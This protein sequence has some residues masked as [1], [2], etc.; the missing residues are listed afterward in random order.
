[1]F[2]HLRKWTWQP[3]V[4]ILDKAVC[5]SLHANALG[6]GINPFLF[7]SQLWVNS[8]TDWAFSLGL[9]TGLGE[10]KLWIHTSS[11]PLIN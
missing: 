11:T 4:Q 5:V 7:L 10:G 2:Y 9:A 6:K 3:P 8:R 1:M